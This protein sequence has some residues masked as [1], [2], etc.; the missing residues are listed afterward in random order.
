MEGAAWRRIQ[1]VLESGGNVENVLP[2]C[3][4]GELEGSGFYRYHGDPNAGNT[5]CVH[6]RRPNFAKAGVVQWN[7][8][9]DTLRAANEFCRRSEFVR[10]QGP[11]IAVWRC[12]GHDVA[13]DR[14]AVPPE[15]PEGLR[16]APLKGRTLVE[17]F[18]GLEAENGAALSRVW[19]ESGGLSIRYDVREGAQRDF[20]KDD[21][22]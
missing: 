10:R 7:P 11:H 21:A 3:G 14:A 9:V 8:R 20:L 4:I 13:D 15:L 6:E 19:E 18:S 5:F 17:T 16:D 12:C 22:Y 1:L 2:S